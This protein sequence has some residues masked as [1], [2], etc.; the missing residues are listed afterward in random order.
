MDNKA[1]ESN[2]EMMDTSVPNENEESV[3]GKL[4]YHNVCQVS[5]QIAMETYSLIPLFYC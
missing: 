1:E 2:I 3:N 5:L 4:K